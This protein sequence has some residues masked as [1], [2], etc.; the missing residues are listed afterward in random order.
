MKSS[1]L[2]ATGV[3]LLGAASIAV[4]SMAGDGGKNCGSKHHSEA[5]SGHE[6]FQGRHFGHAGKSLELTDAQKETLKAQ[7]EADKA[8]RDALHAKLKDAHK[9]L[10]TAVDAGAN[11][12]ELSVLA[13]TLGK[14]QAEQAL[15][16][17]KAQKAFFAVLTAEQKQ[18]LTES[19]G[20]RF[21]RKEVREPTKS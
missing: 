5:W 14:L 11:D 20:K 18:T 6:G 12:A 16:G 1:K 15:A 21:E 10:A 3:F 17:A 4:P 19:R 2:L 8:A 7:S 9:A 13:E